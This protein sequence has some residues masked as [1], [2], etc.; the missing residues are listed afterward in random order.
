MFEVQ[1]WIIN[2]LRARVKQLDAEQCCDIPD[3]LLLTPGQR[4][5]LWSDYDIQMSE[6]TKEYSVGERRHR[7]SER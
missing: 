2:L 6:R 3:F 5:Q 1:R 4:R 7:R